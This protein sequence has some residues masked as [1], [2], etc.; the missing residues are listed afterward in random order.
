M[1]NIINLP[2]LSQ[3]IIETI[4]ISHIIKVSAIDVGTSTEVVFMV[5]HNTNR[6]D[7]EALAK[8]KLSYVI[9]NIS[10]N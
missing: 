4:R 2:D 8:R 5:P 1:Q 9:K 10:D 7:I 3:I 6:K